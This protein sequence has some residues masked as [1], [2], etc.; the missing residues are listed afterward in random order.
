MIFLSLTHLFCFCFVL[1]LNT[2]FCSLLIFLIFLKH[3]KLS[4]NCEYI[5]PTLRDLL[6][7]TVTK[8]DTQESVTKVSWKANGSILQ[9]V[10]HCYHVIIAKDGIEKIDDNVEGL[11]YES[12][13]VFTGKVSVSVSSVFK[14]NDKIVSES[15]PRTL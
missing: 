8:P 1:F 12:S 5:H 3:Q 6:I 9:G 4:G 13:T 7:I 15:T 11:F 2:E 10:E 14:K